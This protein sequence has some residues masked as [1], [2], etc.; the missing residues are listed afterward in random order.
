VTSFISALSEQLHHQSAELTQDQLHQL[1]VHFELMTKWNKTHNLTRIVD[2]RAAAEKH[3][4]DCLKGLDW[5]PDSCVAHDFGSGA[6]FPG[7]VAAIAR[8]HQN[9][10]LVE[11]ARKRASFLER[12]VKTI[13]LT[14]AAVAHCRAQE[15]TDLELVIS[16]GTFSWPNFEP[17]VDSL[18]ILGQLALWLG[19]T[20]T[21]KEFHEGM[22]QKGLQTDWFSYELPLSGLRHMGRAIKTQP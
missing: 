9:F 20:P 7:L 17:L 11:P 19:H 22:G 21:E 5:V 16:R 6:G 2:G 13:G 18:K 4:L 15:L 3:Y 14:N 8:P 10:V 12:A 1:G